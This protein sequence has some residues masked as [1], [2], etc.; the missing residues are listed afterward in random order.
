LDATTERPLDKI[1]APRLRVFQQQGKRLAIRLEVIFWS[2]LRDF[3]TEDKL[4]LGQLIFKILATLPPDTNMTA[5]LR[6]YCLDRQRRHSSL[7]RM[8]AIGFDL[9]ALIAA[10]PTPV[11]VITPNRKITAINPAFSSLMSAQRGELEKSEALHI[12]FAEPIKAIQQRLLDQPQKISVLQVGFVTG[13]I[14]RQHHARFALAD[15]SKGLDSL[16]VLFVQLG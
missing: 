14:S 15:R 9:M 6:C 10:C 5:G 1:M 8:S 7:Q 11:V 16:I 4:S 13:K 3:A 2:Q 12:T